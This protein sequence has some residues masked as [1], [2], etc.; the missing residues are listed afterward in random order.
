MQPSE[1]G[2]NGAV[3]P[4]SVVVAE[5]RPPALAVTVMVPGPVARTR[6]YASPW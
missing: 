6:A 2:T 5:V 3:V 4:V 1:H